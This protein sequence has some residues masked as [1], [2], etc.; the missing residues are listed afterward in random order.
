MEGDKRGEGQGARTLRGGGSVEEAGC[1]EA[2]DNRKKNDTTVHNILHSERR[3]EA[4]ANKKGA[5]TRI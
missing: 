1:R 4:E 5:G 3:K 2:G